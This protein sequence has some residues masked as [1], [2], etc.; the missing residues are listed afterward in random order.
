M[1]ASETD[2]KWQWAAVQRVTNT[3]LLGISPVFTS[4]N[5]AV[6]WVDSQM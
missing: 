2:W 5:K 1:L 4:Y 6:E 3:Y